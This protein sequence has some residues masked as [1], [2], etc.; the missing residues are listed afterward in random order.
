MTEINP[1]EVLFEF[2]RMGA[3]VKVTA[4]HPATLTEVSITGDAK[5]P[6]SYLQKLA[7]NKLALQLKKQKSV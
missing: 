4:L 5:A 6:Q 3:Y 7:L 2:R 1:G